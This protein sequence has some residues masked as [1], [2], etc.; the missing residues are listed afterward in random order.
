MIASELEA[1]GR[2]QYIGLYVLICAV[3]LAPERT[4][5]FGFLGLVGG[6]VA[7]VMVERQY[8]GAVTGHQ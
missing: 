5:R 7:A 2:D 6:F 4:R 3:M 1:W 8:P